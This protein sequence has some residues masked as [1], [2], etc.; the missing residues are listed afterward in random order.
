MVLFGEFAKK[1]GLEVN[2][3]ERENCEDGSG[4]SEQGQTS[5]KDVERFSGKTGEKKPVSKQEA[6]TPSKRNKGQVASKL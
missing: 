5:A 1:A 6:V 3:Q 2:L 4:E